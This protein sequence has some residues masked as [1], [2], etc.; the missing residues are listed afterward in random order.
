MT[1]RTAASRAPRVSFPLLLAVGLLGCGAAAPEVVAPT[2]FTEQD[3]ELFDRGISYINDPAA[4]GGGWEAE[5][6]EALELRVQ[7]A[8]AVAIATGHTFREDTNPRQQRTHRLSL[9]LDTRL[10]GE[11]PDELDLISRPGDPGFESVDGQEARILQKRFVVFV[12]WQLNEETGAREA[13]FH[14]EPASETV[15]ARVNELVERMH[16]VSIGP[17][18]T[19]HYN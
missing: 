16:G 5:W 15:R 18:T 12:K 7:H 2:P 1:C 10:Y 14:L 19:V 17:R 6:S 13:A 3:T 11:L 4:L 9:A 8:D